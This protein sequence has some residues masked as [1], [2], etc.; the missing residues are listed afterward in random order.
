M[1]CF[2][3]QQNESDGSKEKARNQDSEPRLE[4]ENEQD[5]KH[6]QPTPAVTPGFQLFVYLLD[7][8][9]FFALMLLL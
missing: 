7:F 2:C 8:I 4:Q 9:C 6:K 5:N 1:R 3:S